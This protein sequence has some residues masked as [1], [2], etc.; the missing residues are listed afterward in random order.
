MSSL[1]HQFGQI[2]GKTD[3]GFA[4]VTKP[5]IFSK[6]FRCISIEPEV[7]FQAE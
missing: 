5:Y 3:E 4:K 2:V 7:K 1:P 6:T